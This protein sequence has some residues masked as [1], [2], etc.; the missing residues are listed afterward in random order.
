[1]DDGYGM[2][3]ALNEPGEDGRG[4]VVR[5]RH[6]IIVNDIK[7]SIRQMRIMSK[8]LNLKPLI[9]FKKRNLARPI[10]NPAQ[11]AQRQLDSSKFVG[12]N[13]KLP[14]N[15]HLLTLEPWTDGRILV[16]LEHLF[17]INEDPKYSK[18]RRISLRDL[19]AP[20]IV[21]NVEEMTLSANQWKRPAEERRLKWTPEVNP[22]ANYTN[23]LTQLDTD[24]LGNQCDHYLLCVLT[25]LDLYQ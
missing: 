4:L 19:F 15:L 21:V 17:E 9:A 11:R 13:K 16:R 6:R 14:P 10:R 25:L 2:D 24:D 7:E 23:V 20:F 3:E 8:S 18:P 22:Y 12:L 1:M 5:G